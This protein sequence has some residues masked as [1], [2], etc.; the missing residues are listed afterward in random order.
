MSV[1]III[2]LFL[3]QK[4]YVCHICST[5]FEYPNPLKLHL[6]LD[7]DKQPI[8]TLW[9]RLSKSMSSTTIETKHVFGLELKA[10]ESSKSFKKSYS[11]LN[12][13][14]SA[15][16]LKISTDNTLSI[17]SSKLSPLNNT[18]SNIPTTINLDLAAKSLNSGTD[19]QRSSSVTGTLHSSAFKPYSTSRISRNNNSIDLSQSNSNFTNFL[20]N[21]QPQAIPTIATQNYSSIVDCNHAAQME[22]L[23]SNLGKSKQGHLCIYCGKC[24]S[25]KYGLKIHIRTHTGY[26]PLKCKYCLRPF[27]DPSNLN[28]HVRLH[29]EGDTPYKYVF[30]YYFRINSIL[31]NLQFKLLLLIYFQM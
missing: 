23:V 25:R 2:F 9:D 18:V 14:K 27:G 6:T 7:C 10:N 17:S 20:S 11:V 19:I 13:S 26:K 5:T 15:D 24:Y 4:K 29:A 28:K 12:L 8:S 22:T 30:V 1:I 16:S 31:C 21:C 3:G